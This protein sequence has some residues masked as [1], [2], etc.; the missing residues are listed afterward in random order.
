M[1]HVE[2][3]T[4]HSVDNK[5][6]EVRDLKVAFKTSNGYLQ[7]I[8]SVSFS[9]EKGEILGVVGESGCGKSVTATSILG[10]FDRKKSRVEGKIQYKEHNLLRFSE[11]Q[12]R[13]I[14]GNVI[15]MVHQNP[16][17]SLDPLYTIGSQM[18]E[19]ILLHQDVSKQEAQML[20]LDLL[21]KVGIPSAE[22]KI[23]AYPHQLSGGM[24][25]RAM[26]AIA[27]ACKPD[28]LIADEP[29]TALD[30]TIQ[31]Q[32][33]DLLLDLQKEY[34]MSIIFI[35]HDLGVVAEFCTKVMVMYLGQ[36]VESADVKTIFTSPQHPYTKGLLKSIPTI[37]GERKEKLFTI[38]G[39]VPPLSDIP[40][41]CRFS[42]RCPHAK[43]RC[44]Q[45]MPELVELSQS[46][47]SV[48]CWFYEEINHER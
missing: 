30:V 43:D 18:I 14:R 9:L 42:N 47:H 17:T 22:Q 15:S 38:T 32:I 6:L 28:I 5:I 31:A 33:L 11:K 23:N 39:T 40:K 10:L 1:N 46:N 19:T 8:N 44:N 27:L 41:G 16:M 13:K 24:K 12:Y 37:E 20:A 21:K 2:V 25:Q 3:L 4:K 29:T 26:I 36:V 45:E 48:R 34:G 35:T 7:A